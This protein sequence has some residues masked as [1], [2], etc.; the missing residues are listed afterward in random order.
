MTVGRRLKNM[1]CTYSVEHFAA[2]K[3]NSAICNSQFNPENMI[4]SATDSQK[5][6]SVWPHLSVKLKHVEIT[7]WNSASIK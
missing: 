2:T 5:S 1:Q 4:L 6:D 7:E 3:G